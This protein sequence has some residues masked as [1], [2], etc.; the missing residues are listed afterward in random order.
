VEQSGD[1][2]GPQPD[3]IGSRR[4]GCIEHCGRAPAVID[5]F[6]EQGIFRK[7]IVDGRVTAYG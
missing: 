1:N 5:H 6:P 3:E 7:P 2:A 4:C